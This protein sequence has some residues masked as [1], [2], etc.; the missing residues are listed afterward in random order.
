MLTTINLQPD[1]EILHSPPNPGTAHSSPDLRPIVLAI[2]GPTASGKSALG[3]K[4]A[5]EFNGEVI[6]ADS[7]AIYRTLN[8]GTGKPVGE[9]QWIGSKP[10]SEKPLLVE[11]IPHW[12][13]DLIDPDQGYS[14]AQFVKYA[15]EKIVQIIERGGIA[16]IVGGTGLYIS[17]LID[18]LEFTAKNS[19][20]HL[21]VS[22]IY[23]QTNNADRLGLSDHAGSF[24]TQ[25]QVS[26]VQLPMAE[27]S[28]TD[29]PRPY[30]SLLIGINWERE[31]LY[32][33]IDDRVDGMVALGLIPEARQ[34]GLEF[35][36][37]APGLSGIGYR[38]LGGFFNNE[39]TLKIAIEKIKQ[40]S[41][42]YAKRQLTWFRADARIHWIKPDLTVA[43]AELSSVS[44][45]AS[46]LV[47]EFLTKGPVVKES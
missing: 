10:G 22:Q 6:S 30:N 31:E 19:T 29:R 42:N 14:A 33:R 25:L 5:K 43:Q 1:R 7:R 36:F 47:T 27:W 12:G 17:G 15:D 16:I 11:G 45:E 37:E 18:R 44:A 24:N 3:I 9:K 13:F 28:R 46:R 34:A 20:N 32:K 35:G 40:A 39:I 8:I 4:L 21:I 38:E 2:V 23:D 41:R 26:E